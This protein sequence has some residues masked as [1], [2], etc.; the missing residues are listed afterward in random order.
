M[1]LT[2]LARLLYRGAAPLFVVSANIRGAGKTKLAKLA[3]IIT[4]GESGYDCLLYPDREGE[5]DKTVR[6]LVSGGS[7][8]AILD[9][10]SKTIGGATLD[11]FVTSES[12]SAPIL[13][14]SE[15]LRIPKVALTLC[16]TQTTL[17]SWHSLRERIR[18]R[19]AA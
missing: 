19:N 2:P 5:M 10:A 9:N 18:D 11:S 15:T 7:R 6:G 4:D 16:A 1:C 17:P 14:K 8:F 12:Y 3:G 13:G